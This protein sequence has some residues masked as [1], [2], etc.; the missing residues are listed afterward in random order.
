MFAPQTRIKVPPVC[1][2]SCRKTKATSHPRRWTAGATRRRAA[3]RSAPQVPSFP[4]LGEAWA[5]RGAPA[6][7]CV[8]RLDSCWRMC[9]S[10]SRLW[11]P[12][13]GAAR[14]T[15]CSCSS[16]WAWAVLCSA[17]CTRCWDRSTRSPSW[18]SWPSS[19]RKGDQQKPGSGPTLPD[20]SLL[21]CS[22]PDLVNQ[23]W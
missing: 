17:W 21:C 6:G 14:R 7:P 19:H 1:L 18:P 16:C 13:W 9:V 15:M 2:E 20:R 4:C 5:G 23:G 22:A 3:S 10:L 8:C 11:A 12:T